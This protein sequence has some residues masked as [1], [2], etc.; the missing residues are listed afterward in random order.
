MHN[1]Y[2]STFKA[3]IALII[4]LSDPTD[5]EAATAAKVTAMAMLAERP[6]EETHGPSRGALRIDFAWHRIKGAINLLEGVHQ[7]AEQ[8]LAC[9]EFFKV[10]DTVLAEARAA[11]K[12]APAPDGYHPQEPEPAAW[13]TARLISTVEMCERPD[14][15]D[16]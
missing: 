3:S 2:P 5:T 9:P 15:S 14:M 8:A 7:R 6:R 4:S 10:I 11:L 13:A 16:I 12:L 1:G